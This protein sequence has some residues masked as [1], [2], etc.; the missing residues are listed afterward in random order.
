RMLNFRSLALSGMNLSFR[1]LPRVS[2]EWIMRLWRWW[3][4]SGQVGGEA[5]G[6]TKFSEGQ[7]L[8]AGAPHD[9]LSWHPHACVATNLRGSEILRRLGASR[10]YTRDFGLT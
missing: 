2:Q 10:A 4:G 6:R 5:P 3:C 1:R 7:I 9:H 8:P